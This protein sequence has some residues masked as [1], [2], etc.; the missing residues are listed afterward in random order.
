MPI[1]EYECEC[2]ATMDVA[3]SIKNIDR[4]R[5]NCDCGQRMKRNISCGN[6]NTRPVIYGYWSE[7]LEAHITGPK[8]RRLIMA[9]QGVEDR[10]DL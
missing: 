2:G 8:Q 7:N 9:Q 3:C 4:L 1:Y 6:S 10:G 5:K